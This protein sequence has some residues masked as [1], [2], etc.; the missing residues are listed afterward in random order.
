MN[1]EMTKPFENIMVQWLEGHLD[2][3]DASLLLK[4]FDAENLRNNLDLFNKMIPNP[5]ATDQNWNDFVMKV[6]SPTG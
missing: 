5:K 3:I 2:D 4:G 1:I 6:H